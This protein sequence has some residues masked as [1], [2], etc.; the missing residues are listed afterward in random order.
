MKKSLVKFKKGAASFYVVAFSTLILVIIA[1]SFATVIISEVTRTSN[2]DLSQSAYDSALA[3][4]EDAK[5]AYANYQKCLQDGA[6]ADAYIVEDGVVTC[7]EILYW[8]QNADCD[9]VGHILG[10]IPDNGT[11]EVMISD[12]VE[13][14]GGEVTSDLNQAYTCVELKTILDDYRSTLTTA[15]QTKTVK[16]NFNGTTAANIKSVKISWYARQ[17]DSSFEFSNF[18]ENADRVAFQP[19]TSMR[20]STPPT[21]AVQLF[22]TAGT[23]SVNDLLSASN[24]TKTDRATVYLVPTKDSDAAKLTKNNYVGVYD[25]SKNVLSAGQI[26]ATNDRNS[27]LPFAVYCNPNV[28]TEFVCSAILNLPEPLNGARSDNTFMFAVSAPYGQPDTDF[29]M[30]FCTEVNCG[31]KNVEGSSVSSIASIKDSQ[32]VVDSTGRANDLYR[33]VEVRLE[34]AD[35]SFAYPYYA[36][37]LDGTSEDGQATL[38]KDLTVTSEYEDY[39]NTIEE[40]RYMQDYT[41]AQCRS[42]ASSAPVTLTDRRDGNTYTVRYIGGRCYM[43]QNL[44]FRLVSGMTLEPRTT[45]VSSTR[46]L[47]TVYNAVSVY[48]KASVKIPTS[49]NLNSTGLSVAENGYYYN[50][51][52]ASAGTI[53]TTSSVST[54]VAMSQDVCPAGWK[55]P[56]ASEWGAAVN[57]RAFSPVMAGYVSGNYVGNAATYG[58]W[59]TAT[60][61]GNANRYILGYRRSDSYMS[62]YFSGGRALGISVRCMLK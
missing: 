36:V 21:L 18:L 6:T 40:I 42:E 7:G 62:K 43:T 31:N 17:D 60:T 44:S 1:A 49:S 2:D 12:T 33:R 8:M 25:G 38:E 24:G 5:I 3:G 23:F 46:R 35:T 56:T 59:W 10:R 30:E 53:C 55:I 58:Y 34:P 4:V 50:Y 54:T 47:S 22:Q 11:G 57:S 52:A 14:S 27:N 61:N 20:V 9:M 29:S 41:L 48:E 19:A 45:N 32:V 37:Q 28:D 15:N 26:A 51:C 16:V 13:T 39:G